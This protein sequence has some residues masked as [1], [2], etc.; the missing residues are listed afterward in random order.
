MYIKN[1]LDP[2]FEPEVE[3]RMFSAV[4]ESLVLEVIV[5]SCGSSSMG[6]GAYCF[7]RFP[8]LVLVEKKGGGEVTA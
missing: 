3:G 4:L 8:D 2:E 1:L 6:Y 5:D 7:P